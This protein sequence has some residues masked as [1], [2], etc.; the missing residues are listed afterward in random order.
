MQKKNTKPCFCLRDIIV[1]KDHER[2]KG[3]QVFGYSEL[4]F[5]ISL[6][7]FSFTLVLLVIV[8]L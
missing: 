3:S 8:L 4:N 7:F 6:L 2:N 1:N 5:Y